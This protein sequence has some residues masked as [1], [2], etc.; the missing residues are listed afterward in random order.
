[1]GIKI[2]ASLIVLLWA[3]S[4][5]AA[6]SFTNGKWETS[7][8]TCPEGSGY[9]ATLC[10]NLDWGNAYTDGGNATQIT[11]SANNSAGLGGR[12]VRFWN[13]DGQNMNSATLRVEFPTLQAE[14]WIRWYTRYQSG[15]S[16]S[17]STPSY[18]K[19]LYITGDIDIIPE[20]HD[21]NNGPEYSV[22]TQGAAD[23]YQI[24]TTDFGWSH[25]MGG[26]TGDGQWHCYE[27]HIKRDTT[28]GAPHNGVG[29][30]WIDGILR[31]EDITAEM[32]NGWVSFKFEENQN[33]VASGAPYYIDYDDMV[34]YNTTPPNTD[35]NGK[36]FIGPL[37]WGGTDTTA[38]KTII[39]GASC[40]S[41][42]GSFR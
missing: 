11:T 20:Y 5:F 24:E 38:G 10:D 32:G 16:W 21:G 8:L 28:S 4:G 30:L 2:L 17:G 18:D 3:S 7:F 22:V 33:S 15:Y 34:I 23:Y 36:A 29:Q 12:G 19:M 31:A 41:G 27:I 37:D 13:N 1:M 9:G 40:R 39:G 26:A 42:G 25:V 14:L 35:A 6:I